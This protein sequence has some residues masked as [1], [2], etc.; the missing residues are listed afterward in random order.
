MN[1]IILI[2]IVI[3]FF[4]F[5]CIIKLSFFDLKKNNYTYSVRNYFLNKDYKTYARLPVYNNMLDLYP[6]LWNIEDWEKWL[7]S[8]IIKPVD[9][10]KIINNWF[11]CLWE[12]IKRITWGFK[13]NE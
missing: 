12:G 8:D 5:I 7:N 11:I 9:E 1:F 2:L 6:T 4:C 13:F 3:I 10:N